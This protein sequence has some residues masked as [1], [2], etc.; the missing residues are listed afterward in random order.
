MKKS[1]TTKPAVAVA[2]QPARQLW[3]YALTVFVAL[4]VVFEVYAP[5]L[6]GPFLL[7]DTYLPYGR[8]DLIYM[9]LRFWVSGLRPLLAGLA[10]EPSPTH[11]RGPCAAALRQR[12]SMSPPTCPTYR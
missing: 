3:P 1:K 12:P 8:P 7:D 2:E 5:A 10:A 6:N 9:P 4:C 11:S